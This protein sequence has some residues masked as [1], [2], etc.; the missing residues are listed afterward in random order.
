M[1]RVM[2]AGVGDEEERERES[3]LRVVRRT[4]PSS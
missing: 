4:L 2:S 1:A 3:G